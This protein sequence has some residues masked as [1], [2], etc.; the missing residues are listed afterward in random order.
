MIN[1]KKK[2][3]FLF[4]TILIFTSSLQATDF[5]KL[6]KTRKQPLDTSPGGDCGC[7]YVKSD[8]LNYN[9]HSN[10]AYYKFLEDQI[11]FYTKHWAEVLIGETLGYA[12]QQV[13][14]KNV[15]I[16]P[17]TDEDLMNMFNDRFKKEK[18]ESTYNLH[19]GNYDTDQN[20]N[21]GAI[22]EL[23]TKRPDDS[24][25]EILEFFKSA[26]LKDL[27]DELKK[28]EKPGEK[29]LYERIE[30]F[31]REYYKSILKC[32]PGKSYT[33]CMQ[34][35]DSSQKNLVFG[36]K[37]KVHFSSDFYT[38]SN[39][40]K[41]YYIINQFIAIKKSSKFSFVYHPYFYV[42]KKNEKP[43]FDQQDMALLDITLQEMKK[44]EKGDGKDYPTKK[45]QAIFEGKLI[46][47]KYDGFHYTPGKSEFRTSCRH[48]LATL[49]LSIE[50]M[51]KLYMSNTF[52]MTYCPNTS[53]IYPLDTPDNTQPKNLEI[54]K[55]EFDIK[56]LHIWLYFLR[57]PQKDKE[58]T[59]NKEDP[60]KKEKR[61]PLVR[62][63]SIRNQLKVKLIPPNEDPGIDLVVFDPGFLEILTQ[64]IRLPFSCDEFLVA[65]NKF[66][67]VDIAIKE[68]IKMVFNTPN[69]EFNCQPTEGDEDSMM[70]E[71]YYMTGIIGWVKFFEVPE[72]IMKFCYEIDVEIGINTVNVLRCVNEIVFT[73]QDFPDPNQADSLMHEAYYKGLVYDLDF[74]FGKINAMDSST[75]FIQDIYDKLLET[76]KLQINS[77]NFPLKLLMKNSHSLD[78]NSQQLFGFEGSSG[79]HILCNFGNIPYGIFKIIMYDSNSTYIKLI[80]DSGFIY[81][82]LYI[83]KTFIIPYEKMEKIKD[84]YVKS[85]LKKN[86][87][88]E[89]LKDGQ[90]E[91]I[92]DDAEIEKETKEMY[93]KLITEFLETHYLSLLREIMT[94]IA[95]DSQ[96][97]DNTYSEF[98]FDKM[99]IPYLKTN[100]INFNIL[101]AIVSSLFLNMEYHRLEF[102]VFGKLKSITDLKKELDTFLDYVKNDTENE[103]MKEFWETFDTFENID[104]EKKETNIFGMKD[105]IF[106]SWLWKREGDDWKLG[107]I[108]SSVKMDIIDELTGFTK[109]D[110]AFLTEFDL[111]YLKEK[112]IYNQ[113]NYISLLFGSVDFQRKIIISMWMYDFY[114]FKSFH[115]KFQN[116]Y[117]TNEFILSLSSY[118]DMI[119]HLKALI[120]DVHN[121]TNLLVKQSLLDT[122]S[123]GDLTFTDIRKSL[124]S[125]LETLKK[126]IKADEIGNIGIC[127]DPNSF[128]AGKGSKEVEKDEN[129]K[130][131]DIKINFFTKRVSSPEPQNEI[132]LSPC[133]G[134]MKLYKPAISVFNKKNEGVF[135]IKIFGNR[136]REKTEENLKK[137]NPGQNIVS[138]YKFARKVCFDYIPV[139]KRYLFSALTQYFTG[140]FSDDL[141]FEGC[142]EKEDTIKEL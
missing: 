119:I 91:E 48:A 86:Q 21:E 46:K 31:A 118:Y 112:Y 131:D 36:Y 101:V 79:K 110:L 95:S 83:T 29:E 18:I 13:V 35:R 43:H 16:E 114:P 3:Y 22:E 125:V 126:N 72:D 107:S 97:D 20:I 127:E 100:I 78:I 34:D 104:T 137:E 94:L 47:I 39:P 76:F 67:F 80:F 10:V 49:R 51:L 33:L 73:S 113:N 56:S 5:K 14:I 115:I 54:N 9:F 109:K 8:L 17:L 121:H 99:L 53:N 50:T 117:F 136:S 139:L 4:I 77:I 134:D 103:K 64:D 106:E 96:I 45:Q 88:I 60:P 102:E 28:S 69:I 65:K 93:D 128:Q 82:E 57:K 85:S 108:E 1:H 12:A 87:E 42:K 63:P 120:K 84:R 89:N 40:I 75:L 90:N 6:R 132:N 58:Y 66:L 122:G 27:K 61:R 23:L 37:V 138:E 140:K 62:I 123:C 38:L 30:F 92:E 81:Q 116:Y 124:L 68:L 7:K 44:I 70:G 71:I 141:E 129:D 74:T 19:F 133:V 135:V 11:T 32:E 130:G 26:T 52:T 98:G 105:K 111:I 25:H 24:S 55:K 15:E 59:P 2:L 142:N 41:E